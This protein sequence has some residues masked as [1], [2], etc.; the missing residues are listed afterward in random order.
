MRC[1]LGIC[2]VIIIC[3]PPMTTA[4]AGIRKISFLWN[5]EYLFVSNNNKK[6]ISRPVNSDIKANMKREEKLG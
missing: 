2:Q 1:K 3:Q 6:S 5:Y 4:K